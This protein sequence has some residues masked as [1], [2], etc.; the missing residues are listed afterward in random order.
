MAPDRLTREQEEMLRT[1][2]S[3]VRKGEYLTGF[4]AL[5]ELYRDGFVPGSI[6]GLS[7]YGLT[8][9][10]LK[11]KY[12]EAVEL[13]NKAIKQQFLD[14]YH[15]VNLARVYVAMENRKKAVQTLEVAIGQMPRN[16]VIMTY[17]KSIGVRSR[18][19]IPFLSRDNPLNKMLGR[20][21][22]TK[23]S[24]AKSSTRK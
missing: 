2:I 1:G 7:Y 14:P 6:E 4:N 13:C 22:A 8:L 11:K 17:W 9:A 19:P 21:R 12:R 16:K 5:S 23:K 15:Y 18:P 24:D 3:A 10:M 20:A